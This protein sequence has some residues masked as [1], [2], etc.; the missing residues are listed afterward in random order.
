MGLSFNPSASSEVDRCKKIFADAIDQMNDLR[1]SSSNP[2]VKRMASVAITEAQTAQMW[3]VKAILA[4]PMTRLEYNVY[5]GWALPADENGADR[6]FLV[7]Y[8]DGGASNHPAHQGY[9][10]W[11]PKDVFVKAYRP[12][13]GISFGQVI[14]ALKLGLKAARTGW[15]GN[16]MWITYVP[17][18]AYEIPGLASPMRDRPFGLELRPFFAMKT[19]DEH[20]VPWVPSI[21]DCLA[22]DWSIVQ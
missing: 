12:L 15:N 18:T 7:E 16:G 13:V 9:I 3:A 19:P 5:R 11:S 20:L 14:E 2:E 1:N 8:T 21:S 6:G 17:E 4:K 10:S 22:E